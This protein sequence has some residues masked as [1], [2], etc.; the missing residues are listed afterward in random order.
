MQLRHLNKMAGI[1]D[2]YK[3]M[4]PAH[5]RLYL[6]SIA[7]GL[8]GNTDEPITEQNF[9]PEELGQ[10]RQ[11]MDYHKSLPNNA[12][13]TKHALSNYDE[14][15]QLI[16]KVNPQSDEQAYPYTTDL[17]QRLGR[18]GFKDVPGGYEI[19]DVYEFKNENRQP[20]TSLLGML[21]HA[22]E[23]SKTHGLHGAAGALGEY[24]LYDKGIPV[25]IFVPNK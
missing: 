19:N 20:Q 15:R 2:L 21:K 13:G 10:F 9:T 4:L 18:F 3:Q 23:T 22:Y 1:S 12:K 25:N 11:I 24:V 17:P 5:Q 6:S 8:T 7:K 14:Y 16:N